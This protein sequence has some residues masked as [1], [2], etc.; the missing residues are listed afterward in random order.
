MEWIEELFIDKRELYLR[1]RILRNIN[2][3]INRC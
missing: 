2:L 1:A 3:H